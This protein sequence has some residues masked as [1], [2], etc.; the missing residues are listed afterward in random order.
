M[1]GFMSQAN[2]EAP[3]EAFLPFQITVIE[4]PVLIAVARN[5]PSKHPDTTLSMADRLQTNRPPSTL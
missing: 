3:M 2:G 5:T 4:T 1:G